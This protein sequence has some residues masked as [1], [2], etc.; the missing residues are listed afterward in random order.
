MDKLDIY[1]LSDHINDTLYDINNGAP[2]LVVME[3]SNSERQIFCT[4]IPP[5]EED[6]IEGIADMAEA[7]ASLIGFAMAASLVE[8]TEAGVTPESYASAIQEYMTLYLADFGYGDD[9][10]KAEQDNK[11]LF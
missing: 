10:G 11:P 4:N 2:T 7:T 9:E 8:F 1:G 6:D 5:V 3:D